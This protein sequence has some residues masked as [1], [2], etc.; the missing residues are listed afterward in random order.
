[1]AG[2]KVLGNG[3]LKHA[4]KIEADKISASA[5]EKINK[6]GGTITLRET[7]PRPERRPHE[8]G[9]GAE[10]QKPSE[11]EPQAAAKKTSG[12]KSASKTGARS[13]KPRSAKN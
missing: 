6:A 12:K 13:K 8:N 7:R 3:E 11:T 10:T 5:R 4:L 2:V 9:H 1:V